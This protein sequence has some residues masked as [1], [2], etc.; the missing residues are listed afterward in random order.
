MADLNVDMGQE[1]I[2]LYTVK[3]ANKGDPVL[4]DSLTLQYGSSKTPN[5]C[6]QPLHLFTYTNAVDSKKRGIASSHAIPP[7]N[8]IQFYFFV[9][10]V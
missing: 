8:R 9:V 5:G 4:A 10:T 1:W 3:S 6:S 7:L 2:A